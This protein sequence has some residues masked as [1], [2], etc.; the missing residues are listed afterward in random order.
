MIYH[1]Q[2]A[3]RTFFNATIACFSVTSVYKVVW[4][5]TILEISAMFSGCRNN[6]A[7]GR[8][9]HSLTSKKWPTL[10]IK[11]QF[12]STV[13]LVAMLSPHTHICPLHGFGLQLSAEA[14][15]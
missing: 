5:L 9:K 1:I 8:L 7:R 4:T 15:N 13:P 11:R 3:T 14:G 6:R 10:H 12:D 2:R